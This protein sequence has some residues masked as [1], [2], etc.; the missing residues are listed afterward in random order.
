MATKQELFTKVTG[1]T[2]D[3]DKLDTDK[4][5]W[6]TPRG[7]MLNGE[8]DN[9]DKL[10]DTLEFFDAAGIDYDN[11]NYDDVEDTDNETSEDDTLEDEEPKSTVE[12]DEG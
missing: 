10:K 2:F 9:N 7:A 12:V 6:L 3:V 1:L 5:S 8:A 11:S 4:L